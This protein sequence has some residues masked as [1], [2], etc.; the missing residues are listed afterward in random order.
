[1]IGEFGQFIDEKRKGRADGGG[2]IMLKD[3][4]AAMETTATYV[5][6]PHYQRAAQPACDEATRTDS[7]GAETHR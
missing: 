2:D 3:I 4:A 5:S 6:Y 1:M 7:Q